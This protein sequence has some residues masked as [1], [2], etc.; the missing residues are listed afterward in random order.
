MAPSLSVP[1]LPKKKARWREQWLDLLAG[2]GGNSQASCQ[3]A[4]LYRQYRCTFVC[5][6]LHL[7]ASPT[8]C[9]FSRSSNYSNK[10]KEPS[11]FP[12]HKGLPGPRN[13]HPR[14][15]T[16]AQRLADSC[17]GFWCC[18]ISSVTVLSPRERAA[19]MALTRPSSSTSW[20][21][22]NVTSF[23]CIGRL[24]ALWFKLA[25]PLK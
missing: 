24:S 15:L 18:K 23:L 3:P 5:F 16:A 8:F 4:V 10:T 12:L 9:S 1:H 6:Q 20:Q 17:W 22:T 11:H 7:E 14:A 13:W 2:W 25:T 19:R 21:F